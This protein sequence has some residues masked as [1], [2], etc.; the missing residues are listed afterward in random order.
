MQCYTQEEIAERESVS[1]DEVSRLSKTFTQNGESS[2]L[3]KT[4]KAAAEHA[5]D[6][7]LPI[8]NI[9]KQKEKTSGSSHFGN[10]EVKW[11]DNP[12]RLSHRLTIYRY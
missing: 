8:Y 1:Q 9:W 5:T 3:R 6:F 7:E 12:D 2:I 10:S 11:L 4:D